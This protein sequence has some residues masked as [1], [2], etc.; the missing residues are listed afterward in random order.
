MV[1][2]PTLSGEIAK[3]GIKKA[4]I[5]K[6]LGVCGRALN[7]KLCGKSPFTWPEVRVIRNQF[8]PDMTIDDLFCA[9]EQNRIN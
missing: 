4:V 6:K 5:A 2:Y 9:N 1:M 7:N 3:R 8:F